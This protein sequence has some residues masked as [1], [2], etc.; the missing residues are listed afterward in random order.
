M[1]TRIQ[2]LVTDIRRYKGVFTPKDSIESYLNYVFDYSYYYLEHKKVPVQ[3]NITRFMEKYIECDLEDVKQC[4][5]R[6]DA[7]FSIYIP[8]SRYIQKM[9]ESDITYEEHDNDKEN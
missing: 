3:E 8:D 4:Y 2:D 7:P 5:W 1:T 6:F 9:V